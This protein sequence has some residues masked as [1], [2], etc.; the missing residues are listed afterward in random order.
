MTLL[1]TPTHPVVYLGDLPSIF[2]TLCSLPQVSV[3]AWIIEKNDRTDAV[4]ALASRSGAAL[5]SIKDKEELTHTLSRIGAIELGIVANFGLIL[6]KTDLSFSRRG[7][8][9]FHLGLLPEHPGRY[10]LR[11]AI[12]GGDK[13]IGV[14]AHQM[15]SRVDDGPILAQKTILTPSNKDKDTKLEWYEGGGR[16]SE[17]QWSDVLGLLRI[18]RGVI[19]LAYLRRWAKEIGVGDLLDQALAQT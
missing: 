7:Y 6:S 13:F 14:T 19:D 4:E 17:R 8:V 11:S 16:V 9:N 2:E 1:M 10:P 12:E 5:Y 15:T 18:H 3:K